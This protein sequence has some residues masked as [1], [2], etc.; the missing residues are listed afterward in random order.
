M[1]C[2]LRNIVAGTG[3]SGQQLAV[4]TAETVQSCLGPNRRGIGNLVALIKHKLDLPSVEL[5]PLLDVP[6]EVSHLIKSHDDKIAGPDAV[7]VLQPLNKYIGQAVV[8]QDHIPV[9][10]DRNG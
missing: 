9:V 2:E 4:T 8:F 6:A 1:G 10:A 3:A 5:E 7:E